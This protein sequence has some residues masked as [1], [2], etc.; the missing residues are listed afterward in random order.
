[1][2]G[3]PAE[4]MLLGTMVEQNGETVEGY[5][6]YVGSSNLSSHHLNTVSAD[7]ILSFIEKLLH[8]YQCRCNVPS[9]SFGEFTNRYG[10]AALKQLI[11]QSKL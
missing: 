11:T 6:I 4:I 5:H 7:E 10:V 9:E 3:K 8:F 2:L 1:M